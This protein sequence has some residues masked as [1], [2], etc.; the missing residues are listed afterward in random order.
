MA[1]TYTP[2]QRIA[3]ANARR[4]NL[5]K[6]RLSG[7]NAAVGSLSDA[8]S[9]YTKTAGD[10]TATED[11]I[12]KSDADIF[13]RGVATIGDFASNVIQGASKG[14]EGV[15]DLGIGIVGAIGGI[16]DENFRDEA[17]KTISYD[18]TKETFGNALDELTKDSYLNDG[19]VGSIIENV[20]SGVGQM[21]PSVA[22]ALATGGASLAAQGAA[23]ITAQA[24]MGT[25][26]AQAASLGTLM[27]SAAGT[28]T[29]EAFKEGA[30]YYSG[31]AYGASQ[32]A[33][34][35]ATEKLTGGIPVFGKGALDDVLK[36]GI[37]NSVIRNA[38][39]EGA[40]EIVSELV[41]PLTKTIYKG[42][43]ALKEYGEGDYWKGVGESGLVGGLT[44]AVYGG[45]VGKITKTSGRYQEAGEAVSDIES[46]TRKANKQIANGTFDNADK[47]GKTNR[48]TYFE[49]QNSNISDL[50]KTLTSA[51]PK[52]RAD[53]IKRFNLSNMVNEDGTVKQEYKDKVNP[54]NFVKYDNEYRTVRATDGEV[55]A[56][57]EKTGTTYFDGEMSSVQQE[58]WNEVKKTVARA[59]NENPNVS[60]ILTNE[61]PDINGLNVKN[62][63]VDGD[64][65]IVGADTLTNDT[66]FK[67][68]LHEIG[69]TTEKTFSGTVAKALI[70]ENEFNSAENEFYSGKYTVNNEVITR[71]KIESIRKKLAENQELT[72]T[73][74]EMLKTY[75]SEVG[76]I[77]VA[78]SLNNA[79]TRKRFT[80]EDETLAQKLYNMLDDAKDYFAASKNAE[81]KTNYKRIKEI[82]KRFMQGVAEA[83]YTFKNGVLTKRDDEKE[84]T[85]ENGDVD[86]SVNSAE[87]STENS[88]NDVQYSLKPGAREDVKRVLND[89]NYRDDVYLADVSPSIITSQKGTRN[90]PLLIKPSHIRENILTEDEAKAKGLTVNDKTHYH[91]LGEDLFL[92]IIDDLDNVSLAY[93]GT[94]SAARPERRENYFL[95]ISQKID[96]NGNTINVP[97]YIDQQGQYNRVF[98]DINRIATVFG[99]EGLNEYLRRETDKG[100]LVRIKNKST[101]VSERAGRLPDGYNSNASNT[102]IRDSNKKSTGNSENGVSLSKKTGQ[103]EYTL[104]NA[105]E[106]KV[107]SKEEIREFA[108]RLSDVASNMSDEQYFYELPKKAMNAVI[109]TLW[110]DINKSTDSKKREKL[111]ETVARLTVDSI[112]VQDVAKSYLTAENDYAESIR[113]V[114]SGYRRKLNLDSIKADI[115]YTYDKDGARSVISRWGAKN[116]IDIQVAAREMR[117]L[118]VPID[119]EASSQDII[120]QIVSLWNEYGYSSA[121]TVEYMDASE[122]ETLI[123]KVK[124]EIEDFIEKGGHE[125]KFSKA[126][127]AIKKKYAAE[128]NKQKERVNYLYAERRVVE[129]A[130]RIKDFKG[131]ISQTQYAD[132]TLSGILKKAGGIIRNGAVTVKTAQKNLKFISDW[133]SGA[134]DFIL[135]YVDEQNPGQYDANLYSMMNYLA[136]K[137]TYTSDDILLLAK[138]LKGIRTLAQNFNKIRVNEKYQESAPLAKKYIEVAETAKK[139]MSSGKLRR[140]FNKVFGVN[141]IYSKTFFDPM[142]LFRMADG[143]QDGFATFI[144]EQLRD[145]AVQKLTMSSYFN[146]DIDAFLEKNRKW[147]QQ[148]M[149]KDNTVEYEGYKL[150]K[151]VAMSLYCTFQRDQA[152]AGLL[153]NGFSYTDVD[154]KTQRVR[155][156]YD[157]ETDIPLDAVNRIMRTLEKGFSDTDM[158]YIKLISKALNEKCK[159]AKMKFDIEHKGYTN[160]VDGFYFPLVRANTNVRVWN[161]LN[162]MQ[163]VDKA[164]FNK[165]TVKGTKGELLILPINTVFDRH[166]NNLSSYIAL[167]DVER[168]FA[169][170]YNLDI[171]GNP[172]KAQSVATSY[173]DHWKGI[174]G[175][176]QD[177]M[178]D[179]RGNR[180]GR[181]GES[182]FNKGLGILRGGYA[183]SQLGFNPKV[184][185]TQGSS[186]F[187]ATSLLDADC[188]LRGLGVS[189]DGVYDY[190]VVAKLRLDEN[191]AAIAQGNLEQYSGKSKFVSGFNKVT[192]MTMR[193]I[194]FVD[195]LVIKRLFGA[196][197]LQ[198]AKHGNLPVGTEENKI[199]AG[200]LLDKV[201]FE[202]QQ[203]SIATERS[204]AMRGQSEFGRTV[205]MFTAD[206]MKVVGREIDA[207]GRLSTLLYR[208][209]SGETGLDSQIK[210]AKKQLLK[211]STAMLS[212]ALFMMILAEVWKRFRGQRDDDDNVAEEMAVDY[213]GNLIGGLPIIKDIY[214]KIFEGYDI[215]S[216]SYDAINN[217]VETVTELAKSDGDSAGVATRKLVYA[218]STLLGIP[219]RNVY[220]V[221]NSVTRVASPS[222]AYKMNATFF[223][224][225]YSSDL[226]KAIDNEDEQMIATISGLML[227]EKIGLVTSANVRTE[228]NKLIGKGLNVMPKSAP[229][230]ITVDGE[231][232][233][234]T[235][236]QK[237]TFK[238]TYSDAVEALSGIVSTESYSKASDEVKAKVIKRIWDLYYNLGLEA[239]TGDALE[240][241]A[242]VFAKAIPIEKLALIIAEASEITSD[243]DRNGKAISGSRKRK[244]QRYVQGLK[245]TAVQKYMIMGYLGYSNTNGESAVKS[246][247]K[248]LKMT[249]AEKELLFSYCGY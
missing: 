218:L 191:S 38:V 42:G 234:L 120:E 65:I 155:G 179:I 214:G 220:N 236:K 142:T 118:G 144:G 29:E 159:L 164:S 67:T 187:A 81:D 108:D 73:E 213:L 143:Y 192:D 247:I 101:K 219:T 88:G 160:V 28:G 18:W 12:Y 165:A 94:K 190:S 41:S 215:K 207:I 153:I 2:E 136:S 69:H 148:L 49:K 1:N 104:A 115:K 64:A 107:Y 151:A 83:G 32:G 245:L 95:L 211:S 62:F 239:V 89:L 242:G 50:E 74:R 169:I 99:R 85:A 156:V 55:D 90:L 30:D 161:V 80:R 199:A 241:K 8:M 249:Q 154:N 129:E 93:R 197:Q 137:E 172:N 97:V 56:L 133:Y 223:N 157:A 138:T 128:F 147:A 35:G 19:E 9:N 231:T 188:I 244:I 96:K 189:S 209:K 230:S 39:G 127:N 45:T 183:K 91:G 134:R 168:N 203:N 103:D 205:T 222:A 162:E 36:A 208:A 131:N 227:N 180:R 185:M 125:S 186:L 7:E 170:L 76:V 70:S 3:I 4:E 210:A 43:E 178:S 121:E 200:K 44:S 124:A 171:S 130:R 145:A 196:C 33:V 6:A 53:I 174:T 216:F 117:G 139:A 123:P 11:N 226:K 232:V 194:G 16:F 82:E 61:S 17:Q 46:E 52:Q 26:A 146:A 182:L 166:V 84:N 40:E 15:V 181:E 34:E 212:Q 243:V 229:E 248:T 224:E 25:A 173:V 86:T 37:K 20:A 237:A 106:G 177:I 135:G 240:T 24:T 221:L 141:G 233:E 152:V 113:D 79:I 119:T 111:I 13:T 201:I 204:A 75:N 31:L 149:S 109:E 193:P 163:S 14:L 206:A 238:E 105:R 202:T 27:A 246:Y 198:V 10:T 60:V 58:R 150:P 22:V 158:Q 122:R 78:E 176:V 167:S 217:F 102:S 66:A 59:Q 184:W 112:T 100:N 54:D 5:Y 71:D 48:Q 175:Y 98:I 228:M 51:K 126:V 116:G 195:A 23:G 225:K 235:S 92:E 63:T 114:L 77:A 72:D 110:E 140:I 87:K 68:L 57:L 47:S 21:L 132:E